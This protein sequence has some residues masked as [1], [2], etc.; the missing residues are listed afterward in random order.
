METMFHTKLTGFIKYG[1]LAIWGWMS[2]LSFMFCALINEMKAP[3]GTVRDQCDLIVSNILRI[4]LD[5]K[6]Q[7]K[8]ELYSL[9]KKLMLRC[10]PEKIWQVFL[11]LQ[12]SWP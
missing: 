2:N 10:G 5:A 6:P 8:A 11:N 4:S 9:A 3:A 12:H 7:I 1:D